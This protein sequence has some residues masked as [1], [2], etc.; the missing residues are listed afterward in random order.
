M[1]EIQYD[2]EKRAAHILDL[3]GIEPDP[4]YHIPLNETKALVN[5]VK[6]GDPKAMLGLLA[7]RITW[8]YSKFAADP[9]ICKGTD[10][11]EDILSLGCMATLEAAKNTKPSV[12][13]SLSTQIQLQTPHIMIGFI[14]QGV[15]VPGTM[16]QNGQRARVIR[17]TNQYADKAEATSDGKLS[18][19]IIE[20]ADLP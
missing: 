19:L 8:V 7:T 2:P 14:A 12:P 13:T 15:L 17:G 11:L 3:T 1:Y 6:A 5:G 16:E 4:R 10:T 9:R 20:S 18:K